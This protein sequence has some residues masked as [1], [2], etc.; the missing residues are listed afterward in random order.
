MSAAFTP[1]P[2]I[3]DRDA[4]PYSPPAFVIADPDD[5]WVLAEVYAHETTDEPGV[6][7]N[8]Y[9]IAA[10]PDLYEAL[11]ALLPCVNKWSTPTANH[12]AIRAEAALAK[13]GGQ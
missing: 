1:G 5:H 2:W 6:E 7:A 9:L 3:I 10:A 4:A 12:A 13:A 8:A 11:A